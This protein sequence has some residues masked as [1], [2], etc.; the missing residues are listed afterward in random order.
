MAKK[1]TPRRSFSDEFKQDAVNRVLKG[2]KLRQ[3]RGNSGS[4]QTISI[5]GKTVL[6]LVLMN[7]NWLL[8]SLQR[9]SLSQRIWLVRMSY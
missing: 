7:L 8:K 9:R 1:A 2:E 5:S 6:R 4:T 3:L